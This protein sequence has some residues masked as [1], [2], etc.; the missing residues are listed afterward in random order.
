[1]GRV[2]Q[3]EGA[4]DNRGES[5]AGERGQNTLAGGMGGAENDR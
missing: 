5:R 1:M 3:G 4:E 2:D